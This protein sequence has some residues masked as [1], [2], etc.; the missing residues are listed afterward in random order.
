[1][2]TMKAASVTNYV[3]S[4]SDITVKEVPVPA[5]RPGYVLVKVKVCALNPVDNIIAQGWGQG[6]GWTFQMPLTLGTDFAG[7][8]HAIGDGVTGFH[9]GE[10]VFAMNWGHGRPAHYDAQDTE[11]GALAEFILVRADKLSKVPASLSMEAAATLGVA[12][13]TAYECLFKIG[14]VDKGSRVL[15]FG[16][17]SSVAYVATT[18]SARSKAFASQ[19]GADRVIDY[20]AQH[21]WQL[22]EDQPVF[23]VIFDAVGEQQGLQKAQQHRVLKEGGRY[24]SIADWSLVTPPALAYP[25]AFAGVIC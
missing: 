11:Q 10:N 4:L 12:G 7:M 25:L 18:C 2:A 3:K 1:M 24:V 17:S 20:T 16:A 6:S 14:Q 15:I 13:T 22:G 9:E 19:L 23:D 21:W 8:V 5:L